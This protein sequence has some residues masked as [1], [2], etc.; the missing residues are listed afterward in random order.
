MAVH[1]QIRGC[2]APLNINIFLC[3]CT[4]L[5][6]RSF[7]VNLLSR[8]IVTELLANSV[9][10]VTHTYIRTYILKFC[11]FKWHPALMCTQIIHESHL[12][13]WIIVYH[14]LTLLQLHPNTGSFLW[15][16]YIQFWF[17]FSTVKFR[18]LV[19]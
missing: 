4:V 19:P 12:T 16:L 17:C 15:K 2:S 9:C 10:S 13:K 5:C 1:A 18:L 6:I 3:L 7:W 14:A 8:H 11:T